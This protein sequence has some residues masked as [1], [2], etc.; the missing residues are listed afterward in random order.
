M[1][2]FTSGN[3]KLHHCC[4]EKLAYGK[5]SKHISCL[6]ILHS[7]SKYNTFDCL[8]IFPKPVVEDHKIASPPISFI[9]WYLTSMKMLKGTQDV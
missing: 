4:N 9:W 5:V 2:P 1:S 3:M 6:N 8:I 7:S